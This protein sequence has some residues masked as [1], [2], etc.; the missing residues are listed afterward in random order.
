MSKY[1]SLTKGKFA[2]VDDEDFEYLNQ[3]KWY[4]FWNGNSQWYAARWTRKSE[5]S[6]R[7]ITI[8]EQL[9]G[10]KNVDHIDQDGLNNCRSNLRLATQAQNLRNTSS[11]LNSSSRFKGVSLRPNGKWKA[12]I[13]INGCNKHIGYFDT[14]EEAATAYNEAALQDHGEFACLNEVTA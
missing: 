7:R 6:R 13:Q 2:Q 1:I 4:A 5:G 3:W 11:R 8:Q 10:V 9:I 12:Q 14:E